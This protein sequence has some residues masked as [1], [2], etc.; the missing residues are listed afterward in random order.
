[1][2]SPHG[3]PGAAEPRS[4][5]PAVVGDGRAAGT[6]QLALA[7]VAAAPAPAAPAAAECSTFPPLADPAPA[8]AGGT[9]EQQGDPAAPEHKQPV[10]LAAAVH[11][12]QV[13]GGQSL[14]AAFCSTVSG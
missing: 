3:L 7:G 14:K 1:M 11:G 12:A 9:I 2:G 13:R 8:A 4:A 5:A 6:P 10:L